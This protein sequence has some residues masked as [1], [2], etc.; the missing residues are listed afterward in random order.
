MLGDTSSLFKSSRIVALETNDNSLIRE[1][2]RI[3]ETDGKLFVFDS[4]LDKVVVFDEDGKYLNRIHAIGAGPGEYTQASD[5]CVDTASKCVVLLCDIPYKLAY[6]GYDGTFVRE[7]SVPECYLRLIQDKGVFYCA[8]RGYDG[9]EIVAI[10]GANGQ[11][12]SRFPYLET[13]FDNN[14]NGG[15]LTF[16][17]G[18]SFTSGAAPHFAR[19]FDNHIYTIRADKLIAK[20]LLEFGKHNL[21]LE[22]ATRLNQPDFSAECNERRLVCAIADVIETESHLL[23]NTNIGIFVGNKSDKT[24]V[25]YRG[26]LQTSINAGG[27]KFLSVGGSGDTMA[28]VWQSSRLLRAW[29]YGSKPTPQS[30]AGKALKDLDA[31]DNPVLV[32]YRIES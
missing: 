5:F 18:N 1:I 30:E 27:G 12:K 22:M 2:D 3:Y 29:E 17:S 19:H 23:F 28:I 15:I 32:L 8:F 6:Y 24:M 4:S 31:D 14:T 16:V 20:Y 11:I 13:D 26:I 10:D 7:T 9:E 21:P 25:G